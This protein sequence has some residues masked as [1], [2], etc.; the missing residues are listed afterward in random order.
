MNIL[1]I[2]N[3]FP[4]QFGPLSASLAAQPEHRVVFMTQSENPQNIRIQNVEV[5]RFLSNSKPQ[6]GVNPYL[7][8]LEDA[9]FKAQACFQ[10]LLQLRDAGFI[11]DVVISHAGYGF[12]LFIKNLFPKVRLIGFVEWW[13]RPEIAE[14]VL[15]A[16]SL[17]DCLRLDARN[18]PLLQEI[19]K[20]DQAVCPTNWQ[21]DQ[22]PQELQAKIVVQFDGVDCSLFAP[23]Q[24]EEPFFLSGEDTQA[25]LMFKSDQLLLTYGTRGMEPL[26]GFPEFMRAAAVAQQRFPQLHVVVFGRDR[27]AY[28]Y[29]SGHPSGSWKQAL[30]DELDGQLDLERLHFPGLITYSQLSQLLCRSDLH[31]YFS[32]P[33]VVSWGVFNAAACGCRLLVN[34]FPG[35]EEVFKTVPACVDLEDQA[36]I[37]RA[38]LEALEARLDASIQEGSP[39]ANLREGL[40]LESCLKGWHQ[41][42]DPGHPCHA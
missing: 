13:F 17:E 6:D 40:D 23:Q 33:Y 25:P 16:Q 22:F 39:M 37:N 41:L 12:G 9:V 8:P 15:G 10:A 19:L 29:P 35:I 24:T 14:A 5:V 3:N 36:S 42:I 7:R 4:G 21:K 26:R 38:V 18:L 27:V 2:H 11:P 20:S 31:C 28:S 34:R 32:R 1:F 30:L